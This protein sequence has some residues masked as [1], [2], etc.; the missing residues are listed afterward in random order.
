MA[1]YS[2]IP[3]NEAA[4]ESMELTHRESTVS[5]QPNPLFN[6]QKYLTALALIASAFLLGRYSSSPI[7]DASLVDLPKTSVTQ[8]CEVYHDSPTRVIQTS[9]S[10]PSKQWKDVGCIHLEHHGLMTSSEDSSYPAAVVNV[11]FKKVPFAD[12][13]PILGFGGAFTEAAALNYGSLS[14]EGQKAVMELL[15]GKDGLGYR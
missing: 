15:F 12:R 2:S 13:T 6:P 14:E 4:D 8:L 5:D 10:E 9:R 11:D 1:N 7:G 3:A